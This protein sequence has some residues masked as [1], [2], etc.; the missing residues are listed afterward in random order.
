VLNQI[1]FQFVVSSFRETERTNSNSHN[2]DVH[3]ARWIILHGKRMLY[4][5]KS[6]QWVIKHTSQN[7]YVC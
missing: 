3:G 1:S 7:H 2:D 5:L 6:G 4:N